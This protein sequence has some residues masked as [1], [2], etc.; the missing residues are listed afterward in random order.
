[1]SSFHLRHWF[2]F[3]MGSAVFLA[4]TAVA[5]ER[6][7]V[8]SQ[9]DQEQALK[10]VREL[11]ADEYAKA[12]SNRQKS[13]LAKRLVGQA[14]ETKN[15]AVGRF[16][17]LRVARDIAVGGGDVDT[18]MAAVDRMAAAYEIDSVGDRAAVVVKAA[19][20]VTRTDD[21]KR[22]AARCQTIIRQAIA[23]ERYDLADS[24][25]NVAVASAERSRD[26][27][28][29]SAVWKDVKAVKA[30]KKE[31]EGVPPALA[32]LQTQPDDAAANLTVGRF[33]CF[34]KGD[35]ETGLPMLALGSDLEISKSAKLELAAP[36]EATAQVKLADQWWTI[37][38]AAAEQHQIQI[39][40]HAASWYQAALPKLT[41]LNR[42][43]VEKR[44]AELPVAKAATP[45]KPAPPKTTVRQAKVAATAPWPLRMPVKKGQ[46]IRIT[47]TGKWRAFPGGRWHGPGGDSFFLRGQLNNS[48]PFKVGSDLTIKIP[49]RGILAL[50]VVDGGTYDN[51]SGEMN[52]TIKV[53]EASAERAPSR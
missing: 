32:V 41:G 47:A 52:V 2:A 8:P 43:K 20:K 46:T 45:P 53:T 6:I 4:S 21:H 5:A 19:K 44:L 18:A 9:G 3:L 11:F 23:D 39:Q 48:E 16:V 38:K 22:L 35:W 1:M 28:L 42:A 30:A 10:I 37:A 50:G 31:F 14:D 13:E 26:T 36:T 15:D 12:K 17:I 51:N 33:R 27:T 40:L 49:Q 34:V 7:D 25:A 29:A 24:V